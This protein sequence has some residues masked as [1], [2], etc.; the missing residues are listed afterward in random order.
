MT[1]QNAALSPSLYGEWNAP[2]ILLVDLD[3]F[4]ASVEQLDH[5]AWRGKPVIVGGDADKHGVVSTASYEA[6]KFGVRSAMPASMAE[7]LCPHAIWT[8]GHFDR[9]KEVSSQVM[10]ILRDESPHLQQVSID[11]A[12]LDISPT[13][14]NTEH[15]VLVA[16]RI[17]ARVAQLGVTCSIGVGTSKTIAKVASDR[18]KPRGLT[19]VYPGCEIDFLSPLPVRCMSGVGAKAEET[20]K[21]HGITTLG[22]MANAP[23]LLMQSIWGKNADMM[24]RRCLGLDISPVQEDD[25]VK[26]VSNEI[27]VSEDLRTFEEIAAAVDTMA[28]KVGRRL[29]RRDLAGHTLTLKI[30]FSDRATRSVQR[31]L[32]GQENNEHVFIPLLHQMIHELW[33]PGMAVRLVG[34]GVTGF[35][36]DGFKQESL[37][38]DAFFTTPSTPDQK[39]EESANQ[40]QLDLGSGDVEEMIGRGS[41]APAP[42]EK[43]Y[44]IGAKQG[45]KLATAT[46]KVKDRFGEAAVFFG[47]E[48]QVK[49][50]TTGTGAKNPDD[51]RK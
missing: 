19:V 44:A 39:G 47:R 42:K 20:L 40:G 32:D 27:T 16:Q 24:R 15:P 6:R 2:A 31:R 29:R 36:E 49:E 26:S 5:P 48:L 28:A 30:R 11:E 41:N 25:E 43:T 23:E 13:S 7:R 45:K 38:D 1:D 9:Y 37:F 8:H 50:K 35:T 18:D 10:A 22:Q 51:Y 17:Q 21:K 12:F 34:V 33:K 4:F 3:A 46:D 14:V